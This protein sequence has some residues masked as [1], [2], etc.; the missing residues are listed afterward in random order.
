MKKIY[1]VNG[2]PRSGKDTFAQYMSEFIPTLKVS[3]IDKIKEIAK[4]CGWDGVSK[5]ERDRKFLSDLKLLTVEYSDLPYKD[6]LRWGGIFLSDNEKEVML[7]DIREP[8]EI[9]KIKKALN[10]KTILIKNDNVS[11]VES[12]VSDS[13]VLDYEYDYV[14]TNNGTLNDFRMTVAEFVR[15][16]VREMK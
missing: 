16:Y 7:I 15:D 4:Q 5:T 6:I 13:K 12:N 8:E 2:K 3:A 1:I 11:S 9:D 10:A 14:V